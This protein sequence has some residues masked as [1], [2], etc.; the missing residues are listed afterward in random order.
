MLSLVF[1]IFH[2]YMFSLKT[3]VNIWPYAHKL[4]FAQQTRLCNRGQNIYFIAFKVST[5]PFLIPFWPLKA[6][7]NTKQ[8]NK[9]DF[10][11]NEND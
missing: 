10:F 3:L 5:T 9:I 7:A 8:I 2:V 6:L 1:N 4:S 11:P